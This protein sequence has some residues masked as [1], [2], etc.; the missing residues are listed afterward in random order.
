MKTTYHGIKKATC[1][2]CGKQTTEII[3]LELLNDLDNLCECGKRFTK[4]ETINGN[5][6]TIELDDNEGN[7]RYFREE[8]E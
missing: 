7:T 5:F 4:W 2:C 1:L 8:V 6:V 3:E